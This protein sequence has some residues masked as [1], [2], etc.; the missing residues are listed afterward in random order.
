M[1]HVIIKPVFC[2]YFPACSLADIAWGF[3]LVIIP[4]I[5]PY[6]LARKRYLHSILLRFFLHYAKTRHFLIKQE[7]MISRSIFIHTA[8]VLFL[9]EMRIHKYTINNFFKDVITKIQKICNLQ[10]YTS[11]AS[12]R[13]IEKITLKQ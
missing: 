13:D 10:F 3:Q 2:K 9:C 4:T 8:D 1:C 12:I 6:S 7:L 5:G 11:I